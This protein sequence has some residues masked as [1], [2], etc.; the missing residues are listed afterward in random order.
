MAVPIEKANL[1]SPPPMDNRDKSVEE[2]LETLERTIRNLTNALGNYAYISNEYAETLVGTLDDIPDGTSYERVA[3]SQITA[4]IILVG[5]FIT[6]A[7]GASGGPTHRLGLLWYITADGGAYKQGE[8]YRSTGSAWEIYNDALHNTV[9]TDGRIAL[10]QFT[11]GLDDIA[12][13]DGDGGY[14][15]QGITDSPYSR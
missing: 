1:P 14:L 10:T 7:T 4:G 9:I 15:W 12:D 3:A 2:R 13:G 6:R 11:G 5:D 8:I